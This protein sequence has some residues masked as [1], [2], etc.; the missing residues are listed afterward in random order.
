MIEAL[1]NGKRDLRVLAG[2]A[3]G[4]LR[5]KVSDLRMALAG[6]FS[7]KAASPGT[8]GLK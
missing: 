6:R 7:N 4:L 5:C 3:R 8:L 1:I 2:L